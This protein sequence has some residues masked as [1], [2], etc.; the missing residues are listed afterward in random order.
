MIGFRIAFIALVVISGFVRIAMATYKTEESA[1][2]AE[3]L[4]HGMLLVLTAAGGFY[5]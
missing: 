1:I 3:L 5:Q 4:F 2:A